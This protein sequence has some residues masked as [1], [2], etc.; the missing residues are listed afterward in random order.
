MRTDS[1]V[2]TAGRV[3]TDHSTGQCV[4]TVVLVL[5]AAAGLD[6][7][8][9]SGQPFGGELETDRSNTR[10]T[11]GNSTDGS[12]RGSTMPHMGSTA[13]ASCTVGRQVT[14][15]ADDARL[16]MDGSMLA[17]L[18]PLPAHTVQVT[19]AARTR[20]PLVELLVSRLL[21]GTASI[22]AAELKASTTSCAE[23]FRVSC[24]QV[25]SMFIST[26]WTLCTV[27]LALSLP[28]T[29]VAGTP[30]ARLLSLLQ[31]FSLGLVCLSGLLSSLRVLSF[32]SHSNDELSRLDLPVAG[33][34]LWQ[35]APTPWNCGSE[36]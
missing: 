14:V 33:P 7:R 35:C 25:G 30:A 29:A 8:L 2:S 26:A 11:T 20:I 9:S 36:S 3:T 22:D 24:V 5:E 23:P 15:E 32:V 13:S 18:N 28:I 27:T 17:F 19:G 12:T 31:G 1:H 16:Q 4:E 6:E 10:A 21:Y 34:K